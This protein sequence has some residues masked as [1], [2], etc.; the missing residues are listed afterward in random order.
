MHI[1]QINDSYI[2]KVETLK[3]V[4]TKCDILLLSQVP[5]PLKVF[6]NFRKTKLVNYKLNIKLYNL[7]C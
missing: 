2:T 1:V 4:V 6:V 7:G 3:V 5:M